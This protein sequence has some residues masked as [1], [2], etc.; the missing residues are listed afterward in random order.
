MQ[1]LQRKANVMEYK[2]DYVHSK[3]SI[4]FV[5]I[6]NERFEWKFQKIILSDNFFN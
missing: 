5:F 3:F 6:L 4:E 1:K 2:T